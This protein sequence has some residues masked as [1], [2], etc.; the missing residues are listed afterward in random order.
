[1]IEGG[2]GLESTAVPLAPPIAEV[3]TEVRIK[4]TKQMLTIAF[5]ELGI[6]ASRMTLF[7]KAWF[8]KT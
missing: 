3:R 4:M 5:T 8:V 6:E 2:S 7:V 1:M